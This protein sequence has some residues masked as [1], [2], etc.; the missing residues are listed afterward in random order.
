MRPNHWMVMLF[1]DGKM[2][3][4]AIKV[5]VMWSLVERPPT[6]SGGGRAAR[7]ADGAAGDDTQ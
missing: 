7:P 6:G 5:L 4:R 1:L 3:N 2:Y